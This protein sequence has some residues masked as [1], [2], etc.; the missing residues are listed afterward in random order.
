MTLLAVYALY[1][2][3]QTG[4]LADAIPI[5]GTMAIGAQRLLPLMQQTYYGWSAVQGSSELLSEIEHFCSR[6]RQDFVNDGDLDEV[7][8]KDEISFEH[9]TYKYP[10]EKRKL[11]S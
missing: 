8:F 4:G 7:P 1:A 11:C 6:N 5:L 2:I 10:N 9:V 3:T